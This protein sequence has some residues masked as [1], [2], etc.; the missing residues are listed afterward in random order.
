MWQDCLLV[1]LVETTGQLGQHLNAKKQSN[2]KTLLQH[3]SVLT[4]SRV[5]VSYNVELSFRCGQNKRSLTFLPTFAL[6][7]GNYITLT[8]SVSDTFG[9]P[10]SPV[11]CSLVCFGICNTCVKLKSRLSHNGGTQSEHVL[12]D[13]GRCRISTE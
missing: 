1:G 6:T 13:K 2:K 8:A 4:L 7:G 5:S 12:L 10:P 11:E 3:Q 9:K